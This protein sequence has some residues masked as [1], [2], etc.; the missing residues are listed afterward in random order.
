MRLRQPLQVF[1]HFIEKDTM[2]ILYLTIL[3]W[4]TSIALMA[5]EGQSFD[6]EEKFCAD[7]I[8]SWTQD[9]LSEVSKGHP[10]MYRYTEKPV[11]DS[12][13]TV[14]LQTV[15]DS[16]TTI[17]YYRKLKPLFAQIGCLHTSVNLSQKADD[18]Y[19]EGLQFIPIEV[20]INDDRQ[21]FVTKN[22]GEENEIPLESEIISINDQPI[23]EILDILYAA[24]PSD[25]YNQTLK[26]ILLNYRFSSWYQSMISTTN[27]FVV[28]TRL[29]GETTSHH[30]T[31]VSK[32]TF[33]T[34]KSIMK[35]DE[36]QL[37][38]EVRDDIGFLT[39]RTFAKSDI[40][41]NG[42]KFDRFVK[43][44]FKTLNQLQ[45]ENLVIDLRNNT[46]GTDGNAAFLTAHFFDQS[47]KY[48]KHQV[49]MTEYI[50]KQFKFL[51][52]IFYKMPKKVDSTYYWKG[53]NGWLT[54]EF[55]YYKVQKPASNNYMGTVYI[56]T[57]GGCMSSCADLVAILSH[58]KK[59]VVIGQE[60]GGGYQGN[61]SGMMPTTKIK[62][63]LQMVTPLQKYTNAVDPNT[64]FGRG[65]IPD[66][67]V[68][69]T[70][71]NWMNK[72]DA[73]M[74][75]VQELINSKN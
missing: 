75:L 56:L 51:Y 67:I 53:A 25:G 38:F 43:S 48:W 47:F 60:T 17:E 31:G 4:F 10:G 58:N 12:L 2:K 74:E 23:S 6:H 41:E 72:K 3:F 29:N 62:G 34:M 20:F 70:L 21:V 9:I 18:Y 24:V 61:T 19:K 30:L 39:V 59:A 13:I 26:T 50:S 7:S 57:N 1:S 52:R 54:K 14:M 28:K 42:Q 49:E 44:T 37:K 8:K 32:K 27:S 35:G 46:G 15:N 45:L 65:T 33:P 68:K 5:Q 66:Y 11:F 73:E 16:L 71:E 64:N 36:E 55:N 40:R 22:Y 63:N 69:P